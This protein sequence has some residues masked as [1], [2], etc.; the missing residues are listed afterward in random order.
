MR[1]QESRKGAA[2]P[3][4]KEQLRLAALKKESAADID[5][6]ATLTQQMVDSVFS[7]GE[8]GFQEIESSRYLT[9]ILE[10]HGFRITRGISGI[11]TAWVA[12]WGSGKP[13]IALGSDIDG[14]PQGV[15]AAGRR[16]SRSAGRRR[17]GARRR[18]QLR[19]AA[20]HHRGHRGEEADGAREAVGHAA[21]CGRASPRSCSAP[22]PGTC[23]TG[24]SRT[25]T[26]RSSRTSATS[27]ARRGA[28]AGHRAGFH[29]VHVHRPDRA[30]RGC[31][32]ARQERAR[33]GRADEHRLEL[34]P[35]ASA[36]PASLALRRSPTAAISPTSSRATRAS[37]TTSARPSTRASR[38]CGRSATRSP[39]APR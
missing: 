27:S 36:T 17:A 8:L 4:T 29:R 31:A 9:G 37:G 21:C 38:S 7:F 5:G 26:S 10:Q 13:V 39:T 33:R 14:I 24:C 12:D 19:H 1:R 34:P 28:T 16:L 2:A 18:P 20:Q 25:S 15:A 11:P 22:R 35:R 30:Q 23:A 32:L 6:L 3:L